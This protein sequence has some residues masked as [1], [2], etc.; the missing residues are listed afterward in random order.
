MDLYE[1]IVQRLDEDACWAFLASQQ[2]GRLA[3]NLFGEPQ[4]VPINHRVIDRRVY[5]RTAEGTKLFGTTID[6]AVA[7]EV[8]DWQDDEA[9]SV[10]VHG[11]ITELDGASADDVDDEIRSWTEYPKTHV[12]VLT[13]REVTGRHFNL[14][15]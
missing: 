6:S 12:L 9:R 8:D 1:D 3:Y 15:R 14:S 7:F 10:V 5:F 13:P 4:I 11:T 2:L